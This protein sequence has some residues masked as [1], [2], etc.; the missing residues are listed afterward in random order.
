MTVR[1]LMLALPRHPLANLECQAGQVPPVD[2]VSDPSAVSE[3]VSSRFALAEKAAGSGRPRHN[4]ESETVATIHIVCAAAIVG[5]I[6]T[7]KFRG[8]MLQRLLPMDAVM[9]QVEY[10]TVGYSDG[11]GVAV[12]GKD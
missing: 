6:A 9:A 12:E 5:N 7:G 10:L 8:A 4:V 2:Y 11:A 1:P 3:L